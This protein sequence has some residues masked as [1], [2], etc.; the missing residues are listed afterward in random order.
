MIAAKAD[1]IMNFKLIL[2]PWI[3]RRLDVTVM[4]EEEIIKTNAV[5]DVSLEKSLTCF[6]GRG[7]L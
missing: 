6:E 1:A 4:I 2:F 7:R 3:S 5:Y